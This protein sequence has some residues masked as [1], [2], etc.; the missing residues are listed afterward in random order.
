[1]ADQRTG[2]AWMTL[3]AECKRTYPWVCHLCGQP[4]PQGVHRYNPLAYQ[5]DHVMNYDDHPA[6]RMA[7]HNLR[8]SHRRCNRYRGKRGL[9]PALIAQITARYAAQPDRPALRFFETG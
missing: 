7:L 9:T 4:I 8:P 6:L 1:M 3:V 5:A 2:R